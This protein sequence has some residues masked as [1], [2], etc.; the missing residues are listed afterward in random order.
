MDH[1]TREQQRRE[2]EVRGVESHADIA[3]SLR[4]RTEHRSDVDSLWRA[5]AAGEAATAAQD[6]ERASVSA[7]HRRIARQARGRGDEART[8]HVVRRTDMAR[9][10]P[11]GAGAADSL[12]ADARV[13]RHEAPGELAA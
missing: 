6:R 11:C 1:H 4:A 3:T 2:T 13:A 10:R 7:P 8:A 5:R 9:G 12:T